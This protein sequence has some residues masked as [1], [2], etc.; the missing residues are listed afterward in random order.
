MY[1]IT[2]PLDNRTAI[3]DP[4]TGRFGGD[5]ELVQ[6]LRDYMKLDRLY[7]P[8]DEDDYGDWV[9]LESDTAFNV[10]AAPARGAV[11]W[12]GTLSVK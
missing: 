6:A 4:D 11:V 2:Y 8:D 12:Q 9:E 3:Y 7:V 1:T 10:I 5:A